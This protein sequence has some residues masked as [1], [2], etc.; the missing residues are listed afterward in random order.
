MILLRRYLIYFFII[1]LIAVSFTFIAGK[2]YQR[3]AYVEND[4]WRILPS[5]GD[6]NRNIY[7]KAMVAQ[8]GTFALKKPESA[9]FSTKKDIN[10]EVLNGNCLYKLTGEDIES[11]W[12]SITA[13][14]EDGFLISNSNKL[15]SFNSE[16]I[17]YNLDGGYEIYFVGNKHFIPGVSNSNWLRVLEDENFSVTLRVYRPGEEYFSNLKRV[18]LPIIEKI[19][20]VDG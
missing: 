18:N 6:P 13:Y 5:P 1:I 8:Y 4:I 10:D 17:D 9:Y 7:T 14:G 11:R 16:N 20:C 12:W 2:L 15:Y 3:F 19:K